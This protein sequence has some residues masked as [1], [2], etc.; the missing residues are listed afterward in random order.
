MSKMPSYAKGS[1]VLL[2]AL[3]ELWLKTLF[4]LCL[5]CLKFKVKVA[6]C[7]GLGVE[8]VML[9]WRREPYLLMNGLRLRTSC[10]DN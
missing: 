5:C 6:R 8:K 1:P 7:E 9:R 2:F 10:H 4:F 3:P